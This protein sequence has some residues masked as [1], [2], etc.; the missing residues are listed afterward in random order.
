VGYHGASF[1]QGDGAVLV[2]LA[3]YE[4]AIANPD[5]LDLE[6]V[7]A[8]R[9]ETGSILGFPGATD[10][11]RSADALELDCDI[12][13]PAALENQITNENAG[14]IQARIIA[15]AAN[16]PTTSAADAIL[17]EKGVMVLPDLYLNAGGVTVSYFEW[18]KNL[19]H[20][21]FGRMEKRF[22]E[23]AHRHLLAAVEQATGVD[24]SDQDMTAFASGADEEDLVNSGLE[25]TMIG[26]FHQVREV[27]KRHN[28]DLDL[29]TAA[30]I[31]SID[32][33]M[34]CYEELGIFP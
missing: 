32:K 31:N 29:R 24:F 14:R 1:L 10:I 19:S 15:E 33:I 23:Q 13:V 20:V 27:Q 26:S 4:G 17:E 16:G 28:G 34:V 11:E 7:I 9:K 5:G 6:A 2:G 30:F 3:E 18:L 8:H 21:R 12:L 25:E 22:D